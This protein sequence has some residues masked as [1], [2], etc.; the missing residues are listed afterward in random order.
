MRKFLCWRK[1][2]FWMVF[3]SDRNFWRPYFSLLATDFQQ[4]SCAKGDFNP[5]SK[6]RGAIITDLLFRIH[7][8]SIQNF[9]R[10][11]FQNFQ[12]RIRQKKVSINDKE[13]VKTE[14]FAPLDPFKHSST[15]SAS[16]LK[17]TLMHDESDG[18]H[19]LIHSYTSSAHCLSHCSFEFEF[20]KINFSPV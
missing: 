14:S 19:S 3:Q 13:M 4:K 5:K 8:Y 1:Y 12:L 2:M 9:D 17:Q 11:W 10:L 7:I 15:H 20:L 18:S 6:Y 16:P